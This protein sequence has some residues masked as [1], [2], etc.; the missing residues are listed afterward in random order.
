MN[1]WK[2][3]TT[4][5]AVLI[6][7]FFVIGMTL[8]IVGWKMTGKLLGLGIMLVG[9]IFLLVALFVYNAMYKN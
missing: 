1:F 5:R 2:D 6:A 9:I 7:L 4:L 8:T 3:H